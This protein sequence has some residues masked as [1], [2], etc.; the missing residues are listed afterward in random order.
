MNL[1]PSGRF[2]NYFA[3]TFSRRRMIPA[4]P[5]NA[6]FTVSLLGKTLATSDSKT[7]T[8]APCANRRAYLPRT[9][10]EKSYSARICES[11]DLLARFFIGLSLSFADASGADDADII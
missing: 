1:R 6:L 11:A 10:R 2:G 9:P 7:T 8:F 5:R 4:K 3:R